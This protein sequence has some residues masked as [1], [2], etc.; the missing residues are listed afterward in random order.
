MSPMPQS[1]PIYDGAG[2]RVGGSRQTLI[3]RVGLYIQDCT[4]M[5]PMHGALNFVANPSYR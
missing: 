2:S 5:E 1:P 3:P 4:C